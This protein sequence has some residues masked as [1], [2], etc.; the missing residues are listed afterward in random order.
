RVR[1]LL[2]TG[3]FRRD[4]GLPPVVC[5]YRVFGRLATTRERHRHVH[6]EAPGGEALHHSPQPAQRVW[7]SSVSTALPNRVA[8]T[9]ETDLGWPSSWGATSLRKTGDRVTCS[10]I[11][12]ASVLRSALAT[13]GQRSP[14]DPSPR[15]RT[16]LMPPVQLSLSALCSSSAPAAR[17]TL[18][19]S[20]A[21]IARRS[22][23]SHK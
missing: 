15:P 16:M 9:V 23:A 8:S 14:S 21:S 3:A 22:S 5:G 1:G 13:L 7:P 2:C 4:H 12:S 20:R 19:G 18:S 10:P 17:E 6:R 11:S